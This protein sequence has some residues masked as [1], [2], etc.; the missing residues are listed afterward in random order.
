MHPN[1]CSSDI[2]LS[3]GNNLLYCQTMPGTFGLGSQ[4]VADPQG[5]EETYSLGSYLRLGAVGK[6]IGGAEDVSY[7]V[8][9][10]FLE[11]GMFTIYI[12]HE[13]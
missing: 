4:F 12:C 8:D 11:L 7:M 2:S 6:G 13:S 3:S 9:V 10:R 5:A 1:T